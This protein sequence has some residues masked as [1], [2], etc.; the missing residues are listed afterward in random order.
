[1]AK[2]TRIDCLARAA[3][4]EN[5]QK[6]RTKIYETRVSPKLLERIDE[7]CWSARMPSRAAAVR[8]LIE[9]GLDHPDDYDKRPRTPKGESSS[10]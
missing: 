7:Y 2:I 9:I 3:N 1:M 5:G 6:R 4:D 8:A 10:R